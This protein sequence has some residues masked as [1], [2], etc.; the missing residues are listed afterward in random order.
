MFTFAV[1][2]ISDKGASGKRI[3]TSG[4][5]LKQF[6]EGE[7]FTLVHYEIV[8]DEQ[9]Q[10]GAATIRAVDDMS[11]DLVLTT[12][13]TGVSPRDVTPESMDQVFAR[14][15]P[16]IAEAMRAASLKITPHAV[17]SRGRAGIRGQ[18]MIINLPGSRKGALENLHTVL[19]AIH[20]GLLKIKGDD[21]DCAAVS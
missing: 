9:A 1:I 8:P 16:G 2:T 11:A 4:A 7:G 3:D 13:G 12:G 21:G 10:I 5:G 15:I 19:P 14:E 6:L 17:L 18:S 20:H